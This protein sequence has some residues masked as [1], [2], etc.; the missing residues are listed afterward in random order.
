MTIDKKHIPVDTDTNLRCQRNN[1]AIRN[2]VLANLCLALSYV[3]AVGGFFDIV[4]HFTIYRFIS[5]LISTFI[6]FTYHFKSRAIL[7]ANLTM[8]AYGIAWL[9]IFLYEVFSFQFNSTNL[10][11]T[12]FPLLYLGIGI[13]LLFSIDT[14]MTS[15]K[16][17]S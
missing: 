1:F 14:R 9:T 11:F 15:A 7:Y 13:T 17:S 6:I 3:I 5:V 10:L 8:V 4:I 16:K 12:L 2:D